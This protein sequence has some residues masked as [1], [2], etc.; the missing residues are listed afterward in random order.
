MK[1]EKTHRKE[2]ISKKV[3]VLRKIYLWL[4]LLMFCIVLYDSFMHELPFYYVLFFIAGIIIGRLVSTFS[5]F[6][7]QEDEKI[8]TIRSTPTGIVIILL[9]LLI[10]FFIGKIMLTQF[11]I[12]W[13]ADALYLFFIG[14]Y[15][16]KV[17][18]MLRQLDKQ[19]YER[20]FGE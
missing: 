15:S 19:V 4:I 8:F 5:E 2:H 7:I 20:L 11:N 16:A 17:R 12:I 1:N 10:R 13:T 6:Y 3:K 9:L 14:I 18:N